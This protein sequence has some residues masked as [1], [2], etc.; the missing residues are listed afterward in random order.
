MNDT[1]ETDAAKISIGHIH[2]KEC[3]WVD[4]DIASK[5]ERE[6]DEARAKLEVIQDALCRSD[7]IAADRLEERNQLRKVVDE[8]L[9]ETHNMINY[10]NGDITY[11]VTD[12]RFLKARCLENMK[13]F[14]SL[15]HV[16]EKNKTT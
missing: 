16:I 9:D 12:I 4:A 7:V 8:L 13:R 1:H 11:S 6:R 14:N 2:G 10:C 5:L 15:P 3:W